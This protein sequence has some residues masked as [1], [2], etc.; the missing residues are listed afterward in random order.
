[1]IAFN[2]DKVDNSYTI[3]MISSRNA[4]VVDIVSIH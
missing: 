3:S 2:N 4:F 1:M